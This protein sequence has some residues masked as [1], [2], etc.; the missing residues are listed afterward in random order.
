MAGSVEVKF[1]AEGMM[2]LLPQPS[3][4]PVWPPAPLVAVAQALPKA[5][6]KLPSKKGLNIPYDSY[7]NIRAV[8]THFGGCLAT[9]WQGMGDIYVCHF[10]NV[11]EAGQ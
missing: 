4:P 1:P 9:R 11:E 10:S 8:V 6:P 5:A 3:V 2:H 7:R